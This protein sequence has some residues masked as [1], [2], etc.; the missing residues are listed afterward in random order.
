M[1]KLI[2][3]LL[4]FIFSFSCF[5]EIDFSKYSV[6]ELYSIIEQA[7]DAI[8][9]KNGIRSFTCYPGVYTVG[10]DI[11]AGRYLI[12]LI[13]SDWFTGVYVYN[14]TTDYNTQNMYGIKYAYCIS[15]DEDT[16]EVT[17]TKGNVIW[18]QS[19]SL[20]FKPYTGIVFD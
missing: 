15:E 3:I 16:V 18:V 10:T 7:N 19:T 20:K 8:F 14:T 17:L 13:D 5:A 9:E 4:I 2:C 12:S 6:D 1:K 11:P